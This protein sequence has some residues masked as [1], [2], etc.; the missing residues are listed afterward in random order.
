MNAY[1]MWSLVLLTCVGCGVGGWLLEEHLQRQRNHLADLRA[2]NFILAN[3]LGQLE[4]L[5]RVRAWALGMLEEYRVADLERASM[6]PPGT[7]PENLYAGCSLAFSL[8]LDQLDAEIE[9]LERLT[10]E[11]P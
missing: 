11:E 10:Q 8:V 4:A 3:Q 9:Q 6:A 2:G 5:H 1:F 7:K